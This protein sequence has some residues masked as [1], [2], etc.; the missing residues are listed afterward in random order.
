MDYR[1]RKR[2]LR[3]LLAAAALVG[4]GAATLSGALT[5]TAYAAPARMI[6]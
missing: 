1:R 2:R 6:A 3:L 4:C 5:A